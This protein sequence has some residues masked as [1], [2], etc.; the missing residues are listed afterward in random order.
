M[1][2]EIAA[3]ASVLRD[4]QAQLL[5]RWI[6]ALSA[7]PGPRSDLLSD[8]ELRT[9]CQRFLSALAQAVTEAHTTDTSGPAWA[10]VREQLTALS[11][12]RA[13]QGFTPTETATFIFSLKEPLSAELQARHGDDAAGLAE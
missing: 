10:A 9:E 1:A 2:H 8:G 3:V 4:A 13:A 7:L 11:R 12:S 6:A 5:E